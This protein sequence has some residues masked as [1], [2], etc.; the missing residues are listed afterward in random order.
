MEYSNNGNGN[1]PN[2]EQMKKEEK[3]K[4]K[5]EKALK[6]AE[7]QEIKKKIKAIEKE[8]RLKE[9]VRFKA[10]REQAAKER[11][12]IKEAKRE[13][14]AKKAELKKSDREHTSKRAYKTA[15]VLSFAI[16]GSISLAFMTAYFL[17]PPSEH[18]L[19]KTSLENIY[20]K[21]YY[22]L[23]ESVNN[24][25]MD[26]SK[27]L[28]TNTV[29]EQ[30]I[31]LD[32]LSKHTTLAM[33]NLSQLPV[34]YESINQTSKYINQ[35]GDYCVSLQ[36]NLSKGS[37]LT[38]ED[39]E[40]LSG[41]YN[42][43]KSVNGRL[44]NMMTELDGNYFTSSLNNKN[45]NYQGIND[46]FSELQNET[47]DYP[48]LIY[49]GPFSDAQENKTPN[50]LGDKEISREE[51]L[52]K[53]TKQLNS[54]GIKEI[55]S[56]GE[57]DGKIFTYNFTGNANGDFAFIQVSKIGGYTLLMDINRLVSDVSI[58][59]AQAEMNA[60]KMLSD[61]G[62]KN[63]QS[64]WV[65]LYSNIYYINFTTVT[66]DGI[67][68]YPEMIKVKVAGDNGQVLGFEAMSYAYNLKER[69]IEDN[70]IITEEEALNVISEN[71][72]VNNIRLTVIPKNNGKEVLCYEMEC[73]YNDM[74]YL[75]YV[76]A[77][78]AEEENILRVI[79]SDSGRLLI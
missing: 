20:Q 26:M 38:A 53:I 48:T 43:G 5:H 62:Y 47:I 17:N 16:F 4:N 29:S 77:Q 72:T 64:V 33:V 78:T 39:K 18:K 40:Q 52:E 15:F 36:N 11:N 24:I 34:N 57:T 71:V 31:L 35:L 9:K 55:A 3:N 21:S 69:N 41:L 30:K 25:E 75:I 44:K 37:K 56:A 23:V 46:S 19:Y 73:D 51:A 32:N 28:V 13:E 58:D 49:D 50:G 68:I 66:D 42:V 27:L 65:S 74:Y 6:K 76:N 8:N 10:E 1:Y 60:E 12:L 2:D 63:M 7:K 79:D 14:R 54:Y 67:I 22:D 45:G 59:E 70:D 61:L